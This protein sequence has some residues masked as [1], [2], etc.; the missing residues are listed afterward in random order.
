MDF[1][2]SSRAR[3]FTRR[4]RSFVNEY[5][6]PVEAALLRDR[7]RFEHT[8]EWRKWRVPPQIE[9]VKQRA[10]AAWLWI[11]F[12]PAPRQRTGLSHV[13]CAPIA[14]EM[15]RSQLVLERS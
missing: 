3:N 8:A 11:L 4:A 1:E 5:V 10:R 15:G 6:R 13:E 14:Q 12:L 2:P 7:Q 9:D